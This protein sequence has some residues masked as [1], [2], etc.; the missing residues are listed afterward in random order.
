MMADS[1]KDI[2]TFLTRNVLYKPLQTDEVVYAL[3]H[4]KLVFEYLPYYC[5]VAPVSMVKTLSKDC[6]LPFVSREW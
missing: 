3:E 2:V 6:R 4:G 1:K 5:D